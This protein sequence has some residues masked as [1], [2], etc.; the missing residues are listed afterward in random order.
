ML[1]Q[2]GTTLLETLVSLTLLGSLLAMTA[3]LVVLFSHAQY[4]QQQQRNWRWLAGSAQQL[5][6]QWEDPQAYQTNCLSLPPPPGPYTLTIQVDG[7]TNS[8]NWQSLQVYSQPCPPQIALP[9][10]PLK[11]ILLRLH[12]PTRP[13]LELWMLL[14]KPAEAYP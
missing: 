7:S 13:T 5:G 8:Q 11:R 14:A 9:G 10:L 12:H 1:G 6:S 3:P 4:S 2:Y